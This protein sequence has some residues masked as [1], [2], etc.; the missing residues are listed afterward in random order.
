MLQ[1]ANRNCMV[2]FAGQVHLH[3][4]YIAKLSVP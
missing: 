2:V 1:H 4:P 3:D